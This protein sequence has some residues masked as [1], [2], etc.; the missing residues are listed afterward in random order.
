MLLSVPGVA[1]DLAAKDGRTALHVAAEHDHNAVAQLLI[2]A[3]ADVRTSLH[4]RCGRLK[5]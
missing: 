5:F 2:E 4:P 1:V 3:G